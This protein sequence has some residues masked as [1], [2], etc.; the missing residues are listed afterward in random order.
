MS[1]WMQRA[2]E[3]AEREYDRVERL[4]A[5]IDELEAENAKLRAALEMVEWGG[6][7]D[8]LCPH[9]LQ[10]EFWGASGKPWGH[11]SGCVIGKALAPT[12]AEPPPVDECGKEE[13]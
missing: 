9:C 2:A 5:R 4:D 13:K 3:D 8:G 6:E 7:P 12:P 11:T 10:T 1:G